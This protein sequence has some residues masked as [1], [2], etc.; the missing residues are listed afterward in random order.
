MN[1]AENFFDVM[2]AYFGEGAIVLFFLLAALSFWWKST[3]KRKVCILACL[4]GIF[5]M[6]N[7]ISYQVIC[8]LGEGETY[9][10]LLWLLPVTFG[11]AWLAMELYH[12]AE[13]VYQKW[14][15]IGMGIVMCS[16]FGMGTLDNWTKLPSNIYQLD[17][18][19]IQLADAMEELSGGARVEFL[20]NGDISDTIRQYNANIC[21]Y[22]FDT[23]MINRMLRTGWGSFSGSHVRQQLAYM[24]PEYLAIKKES[25][26]TLRLFESS[27]IQ[28]AAESDNYYLFDVKPDEILE[29][30]IMLESLAGEK[31]TAIDAEYMYLPQIEEEY[32]FLYVQNLFSEGDIQRI[33][34]VF[35]IAE[36]MGVDAILV[37]DETADAQGLAYLK[38]CNIPFV[39]NQSEYNT[40]QFPKLT[41]CTADNSGG[42]L[43]AADDKRVIKLLEEKSNV[44]LVTDQLIDAAS[45]QNGGHSLPEVAAKNQSILENYAKGTEWSKFVLGEQAFGFTQKTEDL[46]MVTLIRVRKSGE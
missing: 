4:I 39:Y 25:E 3:G 26:T 34:E 29:D 36:G 24:H 37:N 5:C 15:L 28:I 38:A 43:A 10:R 13:K 33:Q 35:A 44:L 11:A 6:L 45:E 8:R 41:I 16:M 1:I 9:Y 19:V 18:D 7:P 20:D 12:Q 27:G 31:I 17:N 22:I 32:D 30:N 46:H 14:L 42:E 23:E 21:T 2:T 40:L